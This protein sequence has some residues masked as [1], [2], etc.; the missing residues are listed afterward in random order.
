MIEDRIYDPFFT[1]REDAPG[2]GLYVA[3]NIIEQHNGWITQAAAEGQG[4]VFTFYLPAVS[5]VVVTP[6][7]KEMELIS[8]TGRVLIVEPD[9]LI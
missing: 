9:E 5:N 8:G 6:P 7:E 2:L 1:T 4:T 3:H